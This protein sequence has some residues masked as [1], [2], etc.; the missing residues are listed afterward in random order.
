MYSVGVCTDPVTVSTDTIHMMVLPIVTKPSATITS[1]PAIPQP[2]KPVTFTAHVT[3]GGYQPAYQW[4]LNGG[5]VIGAI[6]AIWSA[7]NL[8]P[9][10]KVN[11]I[12]TSND[13]CAVNKTTSSDTITI[14]FPTNVD[15]IELF[16]ISH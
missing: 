12:V 15:K 9:F 16:G 11:V 5:N 1:V 6:Y 4:Q 10:D 2:W 7:S 13:P 8:K 14:G 3:N